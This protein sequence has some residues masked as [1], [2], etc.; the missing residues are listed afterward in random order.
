IRAAGIC[1]SDAHY[2]N[3]VS[4][5]RQLPLI[6][7][8]EVAGLVEKIGRSVKAVGVGE[9]VC[10]HY[11]VTCGRCAFC[12]AGTEQ[13]CPSAEM[14]GKHRD[15]GYAEFIAVPERSVFALPDNIPFSEGAIMMCSSATSLHALSKAR[16][17]PGETVAVFG[18]GGLGVSAV[19]LAKHLGAAEVFAV[20]INPRKLQIARGYGAVGVD[21]TSGDPLAQIYALTN[22]RGVDV[23]LELVG[24]PITMHQAVQSL[25]TLGR[26]ALV[27][28]SKQTFEIAPYSEV[29]NK[30]AEIIGVSDHLAS[31]IPFLLE[32]AA[33][34]KLDLSDGIIRTV[35]LEVGAVNEALDRLESFG[36]DIR[37]VIVP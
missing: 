28:L 6:L 12:L 1:H 35:P 8:H 11:L 29:L 18:V 16:L 13:F 36:D 24:L 3:G 37:V 5:V 25:A 21:A 2:R 32:L 19:Q 4:P 26:A 10:L 31:E 23:A 27:G 15:G 7:G 22:G 20:D 14:I 33:A 9:R 17:K 30:E 34:R